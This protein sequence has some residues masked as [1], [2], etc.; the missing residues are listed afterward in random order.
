MTDEPLWRH[1]RPA[2]CAA[3]ANSPSRNLAIVWNSAYRLL[4]CTVLSDPIVHA[5]YGV[6]RLARYGSRLLGSQTVIY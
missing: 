4:R 6:K 5:C 3:R 1:A 2:A